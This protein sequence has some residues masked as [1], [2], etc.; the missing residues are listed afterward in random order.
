MIVL[1]L[2][3]ADQNDTRQSSIKLTGLRKN[4]HRPRIMVLRLRTRIITIFSFDWTRKL[5]SFSFLIFFMIPKESS[6]NK[7]TRAM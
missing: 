3:Y 4:L 2:F 7:T 1:S 6:Q 5:K